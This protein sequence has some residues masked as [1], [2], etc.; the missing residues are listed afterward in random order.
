[1]ISRSE[2]VGRPLADL[3]RDRPLFE[4]TIMI[5]QGSEFVI[6]CRSVSPRAAFHADVAELAVGDLAAD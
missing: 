6:L 4:D 5:S 2:R 3:E 1:M